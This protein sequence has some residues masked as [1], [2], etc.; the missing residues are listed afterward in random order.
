M[1]QE[2]KKL[3]APEISDE[4]FARFFRYLESDDPLTLILRGLLYVENEMIANLHLA[5]PKSD[6]MDIGELGFPL[7]VDLLAALGIIAPEE[8]PAYLA[9]YNLRN[10]MAHNVFGEITEEDEAHLMEA[11]AYLVEIVR[12]QYPRYA[13]LS[14]AGFPARLR[15]G[16]QAMILMLMA[17][18]TTKLEATVEELRR[19]VLALVEQADELESKHRTQ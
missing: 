11:S 16:I 9:L 19:K 1:T 14:D 13:H 15:Y 18:G 12:R 7:K 17:H 2:S 4:E 5:L 8:K 10:R 6:Q 3:S